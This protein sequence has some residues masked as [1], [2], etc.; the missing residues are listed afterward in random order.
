M[1]FPPSPRSR[2]LLCSIP[3][4]GHVTPML[5]VAKALVDEGIAVRVLT[6]SRFRDTVVATG[7]EFVPLPDEADYDDRV[8]DEHFPGRVG[9]TGIRQIQYDV[10]HMF[11][12]C[13]R[14]QFD[15]IQAEVAAERPDVVLAEPGF[16]GAG[17]FAALPSERRM[18]VLMLCVVPMP[19]PSVDTAP[20]GLGLAPMPGALGRLRNRALSV[21]LGRLVFGGINRDLRAELERMTGTRSKAS[22][23]DLSGLADRFLELSVA[24]FDYPRS[25]LPA[26]VSYIGPLRAARGRADASAAAP[27]WWHELESSTVVHVT[28]GTLANTDFTELAV[29]AMRALASADA[30]VVVSTGGRPIETLEAAFGEPLPAN[31]RVAEYL[32]YDA[33]LPHVDVMVTN[34]GFGGVHAALRYGVP[35]VVAGRTEDKVEVSARVAWSGAGVDL[36]AQR[37]HAAAISE[38]VARVLADDSFR[39]TAL[40]I[41]ADIAAS[42]GV[43]EVVRI[44]RDAREDVAA[45]ARP[46]PVG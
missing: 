29:P 25:D 41:G 27:A 36:K 13:M 20:A 21:L 16:F 26:N 34:G 2:A 6:G 32:D 15:A 14:A 42:G 40:R 3:V 33:F 17:G 7:A 43:D 12:G 44:V 30:L 22:L 24:S 23:F 18:P 38:A 19:L 35:L 46:R 1:N 9:L 4:H 8:L 45:A 39:R 11:L 28:Q 10:S 31:V 5:E 37:P